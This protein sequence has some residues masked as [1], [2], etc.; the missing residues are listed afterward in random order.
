MAGRKRKSHFTCRD[1]ISARF[2]TKLC[3]Y[4]HVMAFKAVDFK[5]ALAEYTNYY[6][7]LWEHLSH[8]QMSGDRPCTKA[9]SENCEIYLN[10]K[11]ARFEEKPS[12]ES[13]ERLT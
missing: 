6:C 7:L 5:G 8:A 13:S 2:K 10:G 9:D 4:N 12:Q 11:L 3:P 1:L